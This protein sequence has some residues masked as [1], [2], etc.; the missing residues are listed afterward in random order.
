M[1]NFLPLKNYMFYCLD[2]FIA[3][4]NLVP[5]FLDVG[6]GIGDV[7]RYVASKGWEGKA[8]DF[9]AV[10]VENARHNLTMF[11]QVEVEKRSLLDETGAFNTIF[12]WDV[13]EHIEDDD[14]AL[15]QVASLLLPNGHA[16][17]SV[18]SN[19]DE[20]R[21]DDDFYGHYRRYTVEEM[22]ARLVDVGLTPLVFW[23]FTYPV[24]WAMRRV[25]TRL[26][27]PDDA[28]ADHGVKTKASST[29]NAWDIP[30]ISYLLNGQFLGWRLVYKIQ[31]SY[32]RSKLS[33]GH[34]MFVLARK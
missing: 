3:R 7:S 34:E 17:I 15:A 29:H 4:Y 5:P 21:W 20:W 2:E 32:F 10:A 27:S 14:R 26:K 22:S 16:L 13:I 24:F 19:P 31:F 33:S 12:L 18:P 9:S 25:Y 23:D 8:I 30:V 28:N 11:P 6:C 1:A